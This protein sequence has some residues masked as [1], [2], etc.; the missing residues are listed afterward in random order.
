MNYP[1]SSFLSYLISIF[2]R[3]MLGNDN[4]L[5]S[6]LKQIEKNCTAYISINVFRA[7]S[8]EVFDVPWRVGKSSTDFH[9]SKNSV[10]T[11]EAFGMFR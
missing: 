3:I 1:L 4:I 6:D 2:N 10:R 11:A 5:M 7:C 8:R 9:S